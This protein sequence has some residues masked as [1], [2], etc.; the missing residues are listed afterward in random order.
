MKIL[1]RNGKAF[2]ARRV[3]D[4]NMTKTLILLLLVLTGCA[5]NV[6]NDADPTPDAAPPVTC[7]LVASSDTETVVRFSDPDIAAPG[8]VACVAL[9]G[10]VFD[11]KPSWCAVVWYPGT[12]PQCVDPAPVTDAAPPFGPCDSSSGACARGTCQRV[13]GGAANEYACY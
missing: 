5:A 11:C 9:G 8:G 10:G 1:S 4:S 7:E 2:G 12:C 6:S 13:P 3:R